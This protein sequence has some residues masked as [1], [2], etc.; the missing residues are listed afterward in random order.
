MATA[1]TTTQEN[2]DQVTNL[3]SLPSA[4]C[5]LYKAS[6]P[7]QLAKID[8]IDDSQDIDPSPKYTYS[9]DPTAIATSLLPEQLLL[10]YSYSLIKQVVY[11]LSN[12]L[13]LC[14]ALHVDNPS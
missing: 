7:I 10:V 14:I 6:Q 2:H 1:A 9:H 3:A 4:P 13:S 11:L 12:T 5:L 8:N